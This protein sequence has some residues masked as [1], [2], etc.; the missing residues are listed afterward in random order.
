MA[1]G[2]AGAE[3]G[4][5]IRLWRGCMSYAGN[6]SGVTGAQAPRLLQQVRERVRLRHYSIRTEQAY[7]S[8]IRRFIL[9][10]GRRHPREMGAAEVER[11]LT[12]GDRWPGGRGY[13]E[14]GPLGAAVPVPGGSGHRSALDGGGG[15]REAA[16]PDSGGVV[17][18]GSWQAAGDA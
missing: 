8:W 11:F 3:A 5:V 13:A 2:R 9:A 18:R 10:N 12:S 7:V 16:A 6:D 1:A 14:P 17:S 15:A 4:G